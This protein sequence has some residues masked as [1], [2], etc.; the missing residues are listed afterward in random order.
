VSTRHSSPGRSIRLPRTLV[1]ALVVGALAAVG[2]P[3][4]AGSGTPASA[5]ATGFG[6][7]IDGATRASASASS[8]GHVTR[9]ASAAG[10]SGA[11][12]S[13]GA[14]DVRLGAGPTGTDGTEG[15][16]EAVATAQGVSLLGGRITVTDLRVAVHVDA[17]PG[18]VHAGLSDYGADG[19]VVD[20]QPV[21]AAPGRQIDVA[22]VGTLVFF[23][24]VTDPGGSAQANGLRLEVT[25][26]SSGL[27][28]GT[29]VVVGHVQATASAGTP[30]PT[31]APATTPRPA[32]E[33]HPAQP[34][35]A[36]RPKPAPSRSPAPA[37]T[38]TTETAPTTTTTPPA[39]QPLPQAQP[40][41]LPRRPAPTVLLPADA[42]GYVFPVY[43]HDVSFT[44][45]YGA[46]RSDTGW[47]HGND[48]FA[49]LGTPILAVADGTLSKVGVNALGGN[50]LWLTD[51]RGNSFYYAHL[52]A[53]APV[54]VDGA[55]VQ[56]G[57]VIGFVGN[58]GDAVTT[59]PH[60]H[61]EVHPGDGDSVDPYPYL[62]AWHRGTS[63]A[64]A[65]EAATVAQGQAP[66]AG[67]ILV[68]ALQDSD[69]PPGD[70]GGLA[71]V[72]G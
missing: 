11:A 33:P 26:P 53:F 5:S 59:P 69:R 22:G 13:V 52:S 46:P 29:E 60:L 41:T 7:L 67:A 16:S 38:T 71:Q 48:I 58:T 4:G 68:G 42:A 44:D 24:Q 8:P 3:A 37:K 17:G 39:L 72:T 31:P 10:V 70:P 21:A 45:T 23:E 15:L 65:F 54:A 55:K 25:D 34:V 51:Q 43:G 62:V 20:G 35:P 36:P 12:G 9:Q 66:A 30:A 32:P 47:H 27:A 40:L 56:A 50:R 49:P 63:V 64:R 19:V 57:Q 14:A 61:F 28:P 18:G 6:V 2:A 1:V